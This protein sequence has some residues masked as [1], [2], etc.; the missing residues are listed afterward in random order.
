MRLSYADTLRYVADPQ[1]VRIPVDQLLSKDYA[2]KR[3]SIIRA[4]KAMQEASSGDF[5]LGSDTV[6]ITAVDGQGNACSFINSVYEGFGTGMVVP[7]TAMCLHNR[8]S[9][10][11]LDP[12]HLNA[13]EPGKR[14]YHTIIP[15]MVTRDD[16]LW[17]SYGVMGAFQ[18]PQGQLQVLANLIDFGLDPQA[19]LNALR[20][21]IQLGRGVV[22]EEGL[23]LATIQ[24]LG[25]RGHNIATLGGYQRVIFGGGQVI[26]RDP[27]TGLLHGGSEPRKDGAA[28]GF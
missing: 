9:L 21:S 13:L 7:G 24:D 19:A 3:A 28:L 27:D 26:A 6:Y 15:G 22:V 12:N 5:N 8:G 1:K 17:L 11:S 25:R 20:F 18:Q 4:D 14:P 10:F 23:P 16:E 2:R